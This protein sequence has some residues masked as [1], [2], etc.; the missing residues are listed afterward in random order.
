M[1]TSE[2]VA[3]GSTAVAAA[4]SSGWAA[5]FLAMLAETTS[6]LDKA[7]IIG[8]VGMGMLGAFAGWAL[9]ME[10]GKYDD[11]PG[12][13]QVR[14]LALRV[15]IGIAVGAAIGVYWTDQPTTSRGM[16]MLSAGI[17]AAAPIDMARIGL[18]FLTTFIRSR[19]AKPP[20]P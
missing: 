6:M 11:A 4:H 3:A 8:F 17:V 5:G 2:S 10:T 12:R 16:W 20:A 1:A 7:P 9:A 19:Q 14:S 15:G 18:E 13:K